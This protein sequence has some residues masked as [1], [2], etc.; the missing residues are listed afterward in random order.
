MTASVRREGV[1]LIQIKRAGRFAIPDC[2]G[3]GGSAKATGVGMDRYFRCAMAAAALTGSV[4]LQP[5]HAV[6]LDGAWATN[7]DEC[8]RVFVRK[9]QANQ[10]GF[11]ATSE[12]YGGGFIVEA[13]RLR[14][15]T[16]TCKIKTR[17][18]DGAMINIVAG[19]ATDIMLSNVQFSLKIVEPNKISRVFP[20]I[21][22]MEINYYR[23]PI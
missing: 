3:N 15:K 9:G 12:Q 16:A 6:N 1:P 21:M 8:G 4:F 2:D 13:D 22:D 14:G 5:A 17:K 11:A 7:A 18:E 19:C 10:I 23:C 20:G